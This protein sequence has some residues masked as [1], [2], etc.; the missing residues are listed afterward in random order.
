MTH[1]HNNNEIKKCIE[2]LFKKGRY[3]TVEDAVK[4]LSLCVQDGI[5]KGKTK[6]N[7]VEFLHLVS[8]KRSYAEAIKE[9]HDYKILENKFENERINLNPVT[10]PVRWIDGTYRILPS[11]YEMLGFNNIEK[12][13]EIKEKLKEMENKSKKIKREGYRINYRESN[14]LEEF[15][16][17]IFEEFK[18]R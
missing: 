7:M 5:I 12:D 11:V 2:K 13:R 10:I 3:F 9:C 16:K 4:W 6:D 1:T 8:D 14:N 17:E 18:P 15:F